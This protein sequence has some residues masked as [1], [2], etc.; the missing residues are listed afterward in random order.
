[1]R[2]ERAAPVQAGAAGGGTEPAGPPEAPRLYDVSRFTGADRERAHRA[3]LALHARYAEAYAAYAAGHAE[4]AGRCGSVEELRRLGPVAVPDRTVPAG[5]AADQLV[6]LGRAHGETL[7]ALLAANRTVADAIHRLERRPMPL[8]VFF[9]LQ[10]TVEGRLG[11]RGASAGLGLD[12]FTL[13]QDWAGATRGVSLPGLE[14]EPVE[15]GPARVEVT[16]GLGWSAS[17]GRSVEA[18][19]RAGKALTAG[20][21]ELEAELRAGAGVRLLDPATVRLALSRDGWWGER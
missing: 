14:V 11:A 19:L 12:G 7:H 13:E 4:A 15:G 5:L 21:V 2:V 16:V 6:E 3:N 9:T 20:S 10:A 17:D 18:G 8:E 1:M